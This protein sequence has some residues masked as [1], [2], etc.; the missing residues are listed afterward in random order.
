MC[1]LSKSARASSV[2][3]RVGYYD[4]GGLVDLKDVIKRHCERKERER[5]EA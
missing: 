1:F 2:Q 5:R 3:G 4:D